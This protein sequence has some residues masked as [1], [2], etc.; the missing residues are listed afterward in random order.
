[1]TICSFQAIFLYANNAGRK[2]TGLLELPVSF[3][4]LL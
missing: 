3:Y 4:F 2:K 1:M